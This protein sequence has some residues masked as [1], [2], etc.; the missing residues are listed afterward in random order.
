MS[1]GGAMHLE[2]SRNIIGPGI[3]TRI[4]TYRGFRLMFDPPYLYLAY[5]LDLPTTTTTMP[6][7][8]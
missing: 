8:L 7:E 3:L 6:S 4:G 1:W 2:S 5:L